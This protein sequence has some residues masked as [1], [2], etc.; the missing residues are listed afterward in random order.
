MVSVKY[1]NFALQPW[2]RM[3]SRITNEF[4]KP[5]NLYIQWKSMV[6]ISQQRYRTVYC[7]FCF[8]TLLCET[9][10]FYLTERA[11]YRMVSLWWYK[12][13]ARKHRI[14]KIFIFAKIQWLPESID[15]FMYI[16]GILLYANP[17]L[18]YIWFE[19]GEC[20]IYF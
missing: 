7:A 13:C 16:Y 8:L 12:Q 4:Q 5:L 15:I 18:L 11:I 17:F 6:F 19:N 14:I 3:V 2:N 9:Y 10:G 20:R 1:E